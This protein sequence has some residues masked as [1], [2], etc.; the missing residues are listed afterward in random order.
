[1]TSLAKKLIRMALAILM[2]VASAVPAFAD[3]GCDDSGTAIDAVQMQDGSSSKVSSSDEG[4]SGDRQDGM[5]ACHVNHCAHSLPAPSPAPKTA[6][7]TV[8]E[9]KL[10]AASVSEHASAR[11]DS[12]DRPPQS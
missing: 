4:G 3:I 7:M 12:P 1:M 5:G 10:W 9:V 11:G 2:L 6:A 8:G